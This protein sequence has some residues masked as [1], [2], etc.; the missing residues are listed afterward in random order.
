M[1]RELTDIYDSWQSVISQI[2]Y[3]GDDPGHF[4]SVA[5]PGAW[6][7]PDQVFTKALQGNFHVKY[8]MMLAILGFHI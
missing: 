8:H 5:G 1:F 6:N 4:S 7:D 3:F 2:E